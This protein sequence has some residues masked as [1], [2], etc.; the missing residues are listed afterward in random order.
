MP[1]GLLESEMRAAGFEPVQSVQRFSRGAYLAVFRKPKSAS[2][3][4]RN[5]DGLRLYHQD[6]DTHQQQADRDP[7]GQR[8]G[9]AER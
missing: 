5:R 3:V 2:L 8:E 1:L 4:G 7:L 9:Q 6:R